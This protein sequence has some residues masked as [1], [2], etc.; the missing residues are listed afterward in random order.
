MLLVDIDVCSH[1]QAQT[2][3]SDLDPKRSLITREHAQQQNSPRCRVP[4]SA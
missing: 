1:T 2:P 3:P 4:L